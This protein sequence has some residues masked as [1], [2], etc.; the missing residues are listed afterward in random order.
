MR[1]ITGMHRID[2]RTREWARPSGG[3]LHPVQVRRSRG[4]APESRLTLHHGVLPPYHHVAQSG[5]HAPH[6][7]ISVCAGA[8]GA[9][10]AGEPAPGGERD[11]AD[12]DRP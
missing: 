4:G 3:A 1:N 9:A 11:G 7:R 2:G 10:G 12:S 5:R 6:G 8:A